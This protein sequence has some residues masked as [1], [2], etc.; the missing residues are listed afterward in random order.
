MGITIFEIDPIAIV[1]AS[2]PDELLTRI[3]GSICGLCPQ[4][5][6]YAHLCYLLSSISQGKDVESMFARA[7]IV[8]V[9]VRRDFNILALHCPSS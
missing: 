8:L 7:S 4:Q 9:C 3:Q 5:R 2:A 1:I 6:T